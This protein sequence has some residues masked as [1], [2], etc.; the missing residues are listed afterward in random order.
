MALFF[1]F[2]EIPMKTWSRVALPALLGLALA[3]P[4]LQ[5]Q[6]SGRQMNVPVSQEDRLELANYPNPLPPTSEV[7]MQKMTE[8]E[9]RDA[10]KAG[11]TNVLI[12]TGS[13]E[14]NGPWLTTNK[15]N[16]VLVATS[17]AIA[18]KMGDMLVAPIVQIESGDP[19]RNTTPG[20]FSLRPEIYKGVL[21]DMA[22][23]LKAQGFKNIFFI[24]DS[25]G[26]VRSDTEAAA[27]ITKEFAGSGVRVFYV[28]E[29]YDYDEILVHEN[30]DMGVKE[31]RYADR[32]HDNY[33]ITTMIMVSDPEAV[34]YSERVKLGKASINGFSLMPLEKSLWHGRQLTEFRA[35]ETVAA[36]KKLLGTRATE[37]R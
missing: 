13:V 10:L 25:G 30:Q 3:A 22:V 7:W 1:P 27:E 8:L 28:P 6:G 29:A 32:F 37:Q 12:P 11:K 23:S 5:A 20:G 9:V 19:A 15:H 2:P 4:S 24:A 17:E 14:L 21:R 31:V 35:D 36:M 16:D 33:Y 34:N 18:R 26:N